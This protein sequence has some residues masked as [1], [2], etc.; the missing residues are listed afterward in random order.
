MTAAETDILT[1]ALDLLA[2]DDGPAAHELIQDLESPLAYWIHGLV[3]KMQGDLDNSRYWYGKAG[4]TAV[5]W[6]D[7]TVEAQIGELQRL[8]C[9]TAPR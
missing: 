9:A 8:L 4:G 7:Q 1:R 3:H 2:K 5:R 6:S